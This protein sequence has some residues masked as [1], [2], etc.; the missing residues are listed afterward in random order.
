MHTRE[1]K[2]RRE[3]RKNMT[4]TSTISISKQNPIKYVIPL[5]PSPCTK[6]SNL[7][8][9]LLLRTKNPQDS[10]SKHPHPQTRINQATIPPNPNPNLF[11]KNKKQT[12]HALSCFLLRQRRQ[13]VLR[14]PSTRNGLLPRHDLC[15]AVEIR[16]I[17][18]RALDGFI[19]ASRAHDGSRGR[20]YRR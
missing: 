16:G 4:S 7:N 10:S 8:P 20:G 15:A 6:P 17:Q 14:P 9:Q 11:T 19:L 1:A 3:T 12:L 13:N 18:T 2:K 5:S